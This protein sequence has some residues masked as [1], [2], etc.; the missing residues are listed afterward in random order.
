MR[1]EEKFRYAFEIHNVENKASAAS[2]DFLATMR[3]GKG[4]ELKGGSLGSML[5]RASLKE[6]AERDFDAV[7]RGSGLLFVNR[8]RQKTSTIGCWSGVVIMWR[9][10]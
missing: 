10:K 5:L 3:E 7:K 9:G 1:S 2:A 4:T 6:I 8:R